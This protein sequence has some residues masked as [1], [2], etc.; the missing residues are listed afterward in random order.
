MGARG[1]SASAA[2]GCVGGIDGRHRQ[3]AGLQAAE[4][5]LSDMGACGVPVMLD[6][7]HGMVDFAGNVCVLASLARREAG[8]SRFA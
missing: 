4:A 2:S 1:E 7:C 6:F 3:L 8:N 5:D